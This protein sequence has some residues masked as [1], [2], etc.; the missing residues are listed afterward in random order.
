MYSTAESL[1]LVITE[2][3]IQILIH[4]RGTAYQVR[5]NKCQDKTKSLNVDKITDCQYFC[6]G[7]LILSDTTL[8]ILVTGLV[9]K[10]MLMV[11]NLKTTNVPLGI[12]LGDYPLEGKDAFRGKAAVT[13][14]KSCQASLF[15]TVYLA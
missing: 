6:T 12:G 5:Q 13:I 7:A 1:I 9:M 15:K 2:C 11:A 4:L 14:L 3:N 8:Y 10:K